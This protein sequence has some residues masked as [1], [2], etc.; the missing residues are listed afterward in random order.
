M[1]RNKGLSVEPLEDNI[2]TW[3]CSIK[4]AVSN[5]RPSVAICPRLHLMSSSQSD[6]PYKGGTFQFTV[7]F[8]ENFPFKAPTVGTAMAVKSDNADE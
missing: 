4:A 5:P 3:K 6:S 2:L 8:P 7:V 1:E